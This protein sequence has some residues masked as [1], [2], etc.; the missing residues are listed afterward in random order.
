LKLLPLQKK[1][2]SNK[3]ISKEKGQNTGSAWW[4]RTAGAP[5]FCA[6]APPV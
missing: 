5:D 2:I 4:G 1:Q 3:E 6:A